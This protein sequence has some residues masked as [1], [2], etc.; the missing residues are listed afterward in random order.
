MRKLKQFVI[1]LAV[2]FFCFS[3]SNVP[4]LSNSPWQIL[5][6]DTD[7]TFADIA[8]TSDLQHGWLVGTK[9]TLFE[10]SDGGDSWQQKVLNLGDEK[11]S[12]SAVSFHNQEGWI[13]GKPSYLLKRK[14]TRFPLRNYRP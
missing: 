2:A 4:S 8:F 11:V 3:C 12:F 6:L 9:S 1:V 7:S 10:T 13:V 14:I 5:T